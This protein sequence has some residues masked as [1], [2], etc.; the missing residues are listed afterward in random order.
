MALSVIPI[1]VL[2]MV[3]QGRPDWALVYGGIAVIYAVILSSMS[4]PNCGKH[5]FFKGIGLGRR[6]LWINEC[7]NCGFPTTKK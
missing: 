2:V 6:G 5:F 4:C 3:V 1:F 7:Q